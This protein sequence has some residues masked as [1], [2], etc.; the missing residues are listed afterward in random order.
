MRTAHSLA[1]WALVILPCLESN[2]ETA[3]IGDFALIDHQGAF[4]R[5]S[6]NENEKAVVLFVQGN[7][8]PMARLAVPTLKAIREKF[9][10]QGV[11]F[12]MLNANVQDDPAS[13][14]KEATEYA[15]DFLPKMKIEVAVSDDLADQAVEA[16]QKAAATGKIGDGKIF[17]S[18][19]GSAVRIRTGETDGEAL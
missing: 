2:A 4:H 11:Q 10:S 9:A 18:E 8:C 19:I 13:I 15:I 1:M 3:R 5:L 12:W 16:I 6:R 14:R 17:V 7:G